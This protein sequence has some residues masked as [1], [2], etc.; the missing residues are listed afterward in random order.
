MD[1]R[2]EH[3]PKGCTTETDQCTHVNRDGSRCG[4]YADMH[5]PPRVRKQDRRGRRQRLSENAKAKHATWTANVR[6]FK[7]AERA[8]RPKRKKRGIGPETECECGVWYK[9]HNVDW[10]HEREGCTGFKARMQK[11]EVIVCC[12]ECGAPFYSVDA[13]EQH[14]DVSASPERWGPCRAWKRSLA[15]CVNCHRQFFVRK[16]L[17]KHIKTTD[18]KTY[19]R[20]DAD[21]TEEKEET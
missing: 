3:P 10:P 8:A 13:L 2:P 5:R 15:C 1:L 21:E 16:A 11:M 4:L 9:E 7:E 18:C 17:N 12:A 20:R 6:A 14:I 19:E